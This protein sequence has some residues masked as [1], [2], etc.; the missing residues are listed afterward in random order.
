MFKKIFSLEF[1]ILHSVHQAWR[2]NSFAPIST[3][4]CKHIPEGLAYTGKSPILIFTGSYWSCKTNLPSTDRCYTI[5]CTASKNQTNYQNFHYHCELF[6][7]LFDTRG[8]SNVVI[9]MATSSVDMISISGDCEGRITKWEQL[10]L[11]NFMY[12]SDSF[13]LQVIGVT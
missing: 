12:S 1:L 10:Q 9:S 2:Y 8:I 6:L 5:L 7:D 11:N 4:Q 3:L 13:N